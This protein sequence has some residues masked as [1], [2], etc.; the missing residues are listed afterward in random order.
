[1][2]EI[3]AGDYQCLTFDCYGTLIDWETGLLNFIQPI[4]LDRDVHV[5]DEFALELFS[6]LEPEAQTEGGNY[7]GVLRKVLEG[8]GT[9][10]GFVPHEDELSGISDSIKDWPAFPDTVEA[11]KQLK[12]N[13]KL[14]P[15]SNIDDEL[16]HLSEEVLG[17][18]FDDVITAEQVGVYKPNIK[19]FE[20]ALQRVEGPLLHVAQSRFH[21]IVPATAQGIQTVWIN[22]PSKGAAKPVDA[23]PTWTFTSLQEFADAVSVR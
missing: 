19:M 6:E 11:L 12:Q 7:R 18:T 5:I 1:V 10:L 23:S 16:F 9:R 14:V 4:L 22:R 13:F 21:D 15:L 3:K 17:I 2:S 20:T 8:F